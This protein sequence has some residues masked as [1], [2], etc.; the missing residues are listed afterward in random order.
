MK[1][2]NVIY[3]AVAMFFPIIYFTALTNNTNE[4]H[5]LQVWLMC[6]ALYL[7]AGFLSIKKVGDWMKWVGLS[8]AVG[9]IEAAMLIYMV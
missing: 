7:I 3:Y 5:P 4:T 1:P 8:F 2:L 9:V 6:P